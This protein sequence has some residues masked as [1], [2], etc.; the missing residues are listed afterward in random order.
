MSTENL[1]IT[2]ASSD[3]AADLI[4]GLMKGSKPPRVLAHY[5][6]SQERIE[7]L[8]CEYGSSIVPL[9][10]DL[11]VPEDLQRLIATV[12]SQTEGLHQ[13]VHLAA[14]KLRLER[15][16]QADLA[17]FESDL[18][19]QVGA[20]SRLLREFLPAMARCA[21]RTKLVFVLSSVTLGV[22]PKFMPFYTVVKYA[23]L[24]LMRALAAEYAG[25]SVDINAV[26]PSMVETRFLSEVPAKAREI[27]ASQSPLRRNLKV[28]EV[29]RV[30]E[31][32]LS[33]S[34]DHLS[35]VNLPVTGGA[36]Y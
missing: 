34:S 4:G 3:I 32:L 12:C 27:S 25:T 5:N 7:Q 33:P 11:A 20:I 30:I 19:V 9:Q 24:G 16:P 10:A 13:I 23:Q 28:G 29:T 36:I 21:S 26:S 31:F 17:S 18:G 35:G 1:L 14:L 15:F 22:P 6:R 2:G 8:R